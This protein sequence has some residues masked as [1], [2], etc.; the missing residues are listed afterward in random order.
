M[1]Q[2]FEMAM[3]LGELGCQKGMDPYEHRQ[4]RLAALPMALKPL[5]VCIFLVRICIIKSAHFIEI[6][7]KKTDQCKNSYGHNSLSW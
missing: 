2:I 5:A 7:F 4:E 1:I 6:V 3:V